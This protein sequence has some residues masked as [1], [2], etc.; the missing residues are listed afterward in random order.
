MGHGEVNGEIY[1]TH[2]DAP[3]FLVGYEFF[4][5]VFARFS[6]STPASYL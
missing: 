6:H 3:C 5:E 4:D 1:R 2:N